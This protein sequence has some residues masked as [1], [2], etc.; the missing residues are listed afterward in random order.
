[1]G[2]LVVAFDVGGTAT[3]GVDYAQSGA[4]SFDGSSG[5]VTLSDGVITHTLLLTPTADFIAEPDETITLSLTPSA[6]YELGTAATVTGTILN[7]DTAGVLVAPVDGLTTTEAGGTA[8][9]TV[10]LQSEP[11]GTVTVTLT[12]SDATEGTVSPEILAF[13]ASNWQT[14]QTITVTGVD[15]DED[16]G[17]V[18]YTIELT[19]GSDDPADDGLT[20]SS[21]TVTNL[22]DDDPPPAESWAFLPLLSGPPPAPAGLPDLV[23]QERAVS[24]DG[25]TVVI[26][27]VGGSAV[28]DPFWV[29]VYIDP[30]PVPTTSNQIWQMLSEEGLA[31]GIGD[32][33]LPLQPGASLTL[34]VGDEYFVPDASNFSG[35]LAAGTPLYA[36]VDSAHSDTEYGAVLEAHEVDGEEYNNI[37][38]PVLTPGTLI[39]SWSQTTPSH[40]PL[41]LPPR[42]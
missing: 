28:V 40:A 5:T 1:M 41:L 2:E 29:D 25:V 36:Q 27:N 10:T 22:D 17:D 13:N 16:D 9:F 8:S 3:F 35:A 19:V 31:W 32:D 15:D 33:A 37:A 26:A 39:M 21:V 6:F 11:T 7:D 23:V 38:G 34:T 42:R 24:S 4:S 12:S 18:T 20:A 14:A 30:D